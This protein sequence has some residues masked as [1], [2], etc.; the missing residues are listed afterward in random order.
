L[1][2]NVTLSPKVGAILEA[3]VAA[4]LYLTVEQALTAAV[5]G[6]APAARDLSWAKPYLKEADDDIEAGRTFS[7]EEVFEEIEQMIDVP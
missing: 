7:A 4:G 6:V 1:I 3:Q 5:M 2:V